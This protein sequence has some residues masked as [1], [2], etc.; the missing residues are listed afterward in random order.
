MVP[1]ARLDRARDVK[2]IPQSGGVYR[3]RA[4]GENGLLYI[5]ES[6]ARWGRLDHLT[7]ARRRHP[8]DYYLKGLGD[9]GHSSAPYFMLSEHAGPFYWERNPDG[10]FVTLIRVTS[11]IRYFRAGSRRLGG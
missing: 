6:G 1:V 2:L 9:P 3:F 7:G 10:P 4:Q 11:P 5:G 8:A